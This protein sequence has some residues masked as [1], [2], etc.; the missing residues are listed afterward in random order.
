MKKL[1]L[2]AAFAAVLFSV[3]ARADFWGSTADNDMRKAQEGLQGQAMAAV[4]LPAITNFAERRL[5]KQIYEMRDQN[6]VTYTYLFNISGKVGDKLCDSIGF[7][8]PYA[9]QYSAPMRVARSSETPERGNVTVPQADP[10]TLFSPASAEGTWVLC[11]N[12]E[13]KKAVPLYV[14]PRIIVSP[15]KLKP[16]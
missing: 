13:T 7:G 11:L 9:T 8:I 15:F 10:N 6:V 16:E 4:G 2:F 3:P 14:E 12:P 5:L 1:A